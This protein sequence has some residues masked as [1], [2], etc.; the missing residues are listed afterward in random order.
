MYHHLTVPILTT[1]R[2]LSSFQLFVVSTH[3]ADTY[4][5]I[6]SSFVSNICR[7]VLYLLDRSTF[8]S[9][10]CAL[11]VSSCSASGTVAR[12]RSLT[13]LPGRGHFARPALLPPVGALRS[14]GNSQHLLAG[15]APCGLG[16]FYRLTYRRRLSPCP[17]PQMEQ[18]GRRCRPGAAGGCA[19]GVSDAPA[20][21][22]VQVRSHEALCCGWWGR[23]QRAP[24]GALPG[25]P[26]PSPS[27]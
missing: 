3:A 17:R 16:E 8:Q 20:V 27:F 25:F 14:P 6:E 1:F 10:P 15:Q 26:Q 19:C 2:D 9:L 24:R 23:G 18:R 22:S 12:P 5:R 7:Q 11:T 21:C 13:L 4:V